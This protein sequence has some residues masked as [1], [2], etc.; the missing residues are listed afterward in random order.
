MNEPLPTD[1]IRVCIK[2]FATSRASSQARKR[3]EANPRISVRSAEV[4]GIPTATKRLIA[5]ACES[6]VAQEKQT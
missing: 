1:A 5:E 6:A 4:K 3:F 2:G